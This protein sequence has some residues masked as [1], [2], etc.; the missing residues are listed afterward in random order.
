MPKVLIPPPYRAPT[1]GAAQVAVRAGTVR[2]C[3]D[4]VEALHPGFRPQVFDAT[5]K[6]HRFV[7]LFLNGNQLEEG[8][9]DT[10]VSDEDELE[11]LAAI[12]GG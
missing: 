4:A 1:R 6:P 10:P 11:V 12:A 2:E 7:K 3:I 9:L 8:A 5:G